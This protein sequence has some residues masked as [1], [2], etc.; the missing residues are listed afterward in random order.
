MKEKCKTVLYRVWSDLKD[1]KWAVLLFGLYYVI[2]HLLLNAFCPLVI[3]T[4]FPCPACGMT[5]A[6]QFML[7]GQF[8]RSF[9]ANP[10]ALPW[11]LFGIY[12]VW[13]RYIRGKKVKG[14]NEIICAPCVMMMVVYIVRM[15][16]IFPYRP[17]MAYTRG[18]ILEK[19]LPFYKEMLRKVFDIW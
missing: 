13:K 16:S 11:I 1:Y 19:I 6:I 12:F 9:R 3:I 15:K 4:G 14:F 17:P 18:N 10:M 8:A 7:T 2:T 5:R